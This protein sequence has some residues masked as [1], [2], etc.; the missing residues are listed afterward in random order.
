M[1]ALT[2][3][4]TCNPKLDLGVRIYFGTYHDIQNLENVGIKSQTAYSEV[5]NTYSKHLTLFMVPTYHVADTTQIDFDPR[6]MGTNTCLPTPLKD[7]LKIKIIPSDA[8]GNR[9][10]NADILKFQ[11]YGIT[12]A[13]ITPTVKSSAANKNVGPG[14]APVLPPARFSLILSGI[15]KQEF[16]ALPNALPTIQSVINHGNTIP[17]D[18][19]NGSAF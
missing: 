18:T 3:A 1:E 5:K 8:S 4:A 6:H 15:E 11:K 9:P 17:P 10:S 7:L 19:E 13:E 14:A 12:P 2:S 16:F